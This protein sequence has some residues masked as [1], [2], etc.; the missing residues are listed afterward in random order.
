MIIYYVS[1]CPFNLK[2]C[3]DIVGKSFISP[4]SY[5]L[6]EEREWNGIDR[7]YEDIK[8]FRAEQFFSI[9]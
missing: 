6:V 3:S 7:V 8:E 1:E 5:T 9:V 4:P 2:N